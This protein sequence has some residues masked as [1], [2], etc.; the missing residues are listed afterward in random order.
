MTEVHRLHTP[1]PKV[2]SKPQIMAA[3]CLYYGSILAGEK[4]DL[5]E[6]EEVFKEVGINLDV[7]RE[8]IQA[9]NREI[10]TSGSSPEIIKKLTVRITQGHARIKTPQE[11]DN[12]PVIT[13]G[14]C[15]HK[16]KSRSRYGRP[17]VRCHRCGAYVVVRDVVKA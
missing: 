17:K 12:T 5:Y 9:H 13:C 2:H 15:D 3:V 11:G 16:W 6:A 4:I 10:R 1:I 8:Y 14:R 7:L